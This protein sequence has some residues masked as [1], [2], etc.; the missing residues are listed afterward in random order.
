[1]ENSNKTLTAVFVIL[2]IVLLA[3][4]GYIAYSSFYKKSPTVETNLL[5]TAGQGEEA[6][7]N[8]PALP[9]RNGVPAINED[10]LKILKVAN[11]GVITSSQLVNTYEGE[12][13]ELDY[14]DGLKILIRGENGAINGYAFHEKETLENLNVVKKLADNSE[15]QITMQDLKLG[16]S[17]VME[18]QADLLKDFTNYVV[19]VKIV[20]INQ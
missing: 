7:V 15:E 11:K 4:I 10:V 9:E 20:V 17:I 18:V 5:S 8:P 2:F 1:M 6:V 14:E 16:D 19:G 12:I 3:E 13:S